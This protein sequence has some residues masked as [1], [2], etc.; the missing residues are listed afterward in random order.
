MNCR[1]LPVLSHA[2]NI[3]AHNRN[4]CVCVHV[5]AH[6]CVWP[7]LLRTHKWQL[8]AA[9]FWQINK[10]CVCLLCTCGPSGALC[11]PQFARAR[12]RRPFV[13][14]IR[15]HVLQ[16]TMQQA[17][18]LLVVARARAH[19]HTHTHTHR[20]TCV[21]ALSTPNSFLRAACIQTCH[22]CPAAVCAMAHMSTDHVAHFLS[23]PRV[24]V[25]YSHLLL[26]SSQR[27]WLICKH[28]HIVRINQT[29]VPKQLQTSCVQ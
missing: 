26:L 10:T 25:I 6:P 1:H 21:R 18:K 2:H 13:S 27:Y 24:P 15:A 29:G 11:Q 7:A 12:H 19:R 4:T 9:N 3:C 22:S 23:S 28:L 20:R 16:L 14:V 5:H 17:G 8:F